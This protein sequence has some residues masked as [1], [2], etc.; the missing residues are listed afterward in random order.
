MRLQQSEPIFN[1]GV[2]VMRPAYNFEPQ[3]RVSML[4]GR[5]LGFSIGRYAT[6]FQAEICAIL[7]CAYEIQS[8]NRPEKY[9]SICSDNLAALKALKAVRTTSLLVHQCQKA[10]N[11]ISIRHV[12]DLFWVPGHDGIR[13]NKIADGLERGGTALSFLGPEP[14]LGVSRRDLQKMLGRWLA[15][16]HWAQWRRLGDTQRQAREFISGPSLGTRA[17]FMTFNRIQCMVVTGLLTGHNTLRR[18]LY[19]LGLLD[20]PLCRKCGVGE[21]ASAHILCC[22]RGFGLTQTCLPGLLFLGAGGY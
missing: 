17:K 12:T 19:L 7:A 22:V 1:M 13:G 8:Q 20:S 4:A 9:V 10:L 14:V 15:N 3:Y 5:R 18:L 6:V 2:D 21:E 16:Q 11:D